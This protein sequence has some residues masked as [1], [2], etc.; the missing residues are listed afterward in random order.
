MTVKTK[1]SAHSHCVLDPGCGAREVFEVVTGRWGPLAIMALEEGKKRHGELGRELEGIS[2]K[3]LIQT[4][5]N[6]ERNGL[7][8]REGVTRPTVPIRGLSSHRVGG[9]EA[10]CLSSLR[11]QMVLAPCCGH[12]LSQIHEAPHFFRR[13]RIYASV[14]EEA[15][16]EPWR[17]VARYVP[18]AV[19]IRVPLVEE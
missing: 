8:E 14:Q 17:S 10:Y 18:D 19:R 5:R 12:R 13:Y 9:L 7:I 11:V 4:L 16:V 2:Q 15:H 3:L 6:L 1:E